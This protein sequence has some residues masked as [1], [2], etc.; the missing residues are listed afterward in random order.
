[1]PRRSWCVCSHFLQP[2][3][4]ERTQGPPTYKTT[5]MARFLLSTAALPQLLVHCL[6]L[7]RAANGF[8][9]VPSRGQVSQRLAYTK[10]AA[11][12]GKSRHLFMFLE[13]SKAPEIT[14]MITDTTSL[15]SLTIPR[16]G[17]GTISWSSDSRKFNL[18]YVTSEFLVFLSP[19]THGYYVDPCY[20]YCSDEA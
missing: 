4:P 7:V 10:G 3:T 16:V 1:M 12:H 11:Q 13:G 14:P 17:V 15:G 2:S 5:I 8:S 18:L 20:F 9:F 19:R 6:L